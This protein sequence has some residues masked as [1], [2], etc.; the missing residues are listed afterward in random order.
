MN[1]QKNIFWRVV[2]VYAL[3][4][5]LCFVILGKILL[6]QFTETDKWT[7]EAEDNSFRTN[8]IP[9]SRGDICAADGRLLASSVP[10]YEIHFDAYCDGLSDG[11]FN[12]NVDSLAICLANLFPEKTAVEYSLELRNARANKNRFLLIKRRVN[13]LQLQ[14]LK[15]FPIFRFGKFK[16]GFIED[17]E[18]KRMRPNG[19]LAARTIGFT[20]EQGDKVGIEGAYDVELSGVNGSRYEQKLSGNYW[21]PVDDTYEI[22]PIAGK[23]IITTI[24][25]NI[26]D[27]AQNAL[28]SHLAKH[29]AHWG[30]VVLME[31]ETGD[32]KA[33]VNLTRDSVTGNYNEVYN[34]AIGTLI[35]PGSTFKL[36]TLIATL[37]DGLIDMNDVIDTKNGRLPIHDFL[38]SDTKEGGHGKI[39]V[40]KIFEMSSNVGFAKIVLNSYKNNPE[41]F[42][43]RLYSM[44]LN[45][46]LG[47]EIEGEKEPNIKFPNDTL[48][49]SISLPQMAIG[50]ELELTPLQ[51]LAFYNAVANNGKLI[52]PRFVSEIQQFG[53]TV[54]TIEPVVLNPAICSQ[55]TILK[56]KEALLGVVERGTATNIRDAN[57]Q[58]AGKTGTA[59]IA[60]GKTGYKDLDNKVEYRASFVGYFP[61]DKPKYSCIV[62]VS[63]P[64]NTQYYGNVVA[65][66]VFKE[67]ADKL[68]VT[69]LDLHSSINSVENQNIVAP[70]SKNGYKTDLDLIFSVLGIDITFTKIINSPW[71]A[72]TKLENAVQFDNYLVQTQVV[73]KVVG[74]GARDAVYILE[75]IGLKVEIQ[76]RGMV[77][78][79]SIE[80]GTAVRRGEVIKLELT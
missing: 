78:F 16:G 37:E 45:Q 71:V 61:A 19:N 42:I 26:Q 22:E 3:V 28:Q 34:F 35:E 20:N 68:Y 17:Q 18:D 47:V 49:S 38:I 66:P 70:Y 24:D 8:I 48:W 69:N 43:N 6:L 56:V 57:Y 5:V 40:Q 51:I 74:M 50:Y 53:S 73:P 64:S 4:I 72:T 10:F 80:P 55:A 75:S 31:V 23:D 7:K 76:G 30:T 79:Q 9:A 60:R 29:Q 12:S 27:V 46:T 58:I 32:I 33:I 21:V 67:I 15:T 77:R 14:Q 44:G 54:R 1:V 65:G 63:T 62:V 13:F 25:L 52:K 2:A 59:Q 36:A 39:S 11:T 41:K